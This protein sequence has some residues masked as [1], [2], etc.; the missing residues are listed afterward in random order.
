MNYVAISESGWN[1]RRK[2]HQLMKLFKT[3]NIAVVDC[4]RVN[5]GLNLP[6]ALWSKRVRELDSKFASQS[7]NQPDFLV[8]SQPCGW[9]KSHTNFIYMT[10][11]NVDN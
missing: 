7:I 3:A 10:A 6:G 1:V 5:F 8:I 11:Q 9:M 4:Y 2:Q